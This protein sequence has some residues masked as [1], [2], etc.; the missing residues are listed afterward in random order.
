MTDIGERNAEVG[1]SRYAVSNDGNL[2]SGFSS[3]PFWGASNA[4][5]WTPEAGMVREFSGNPANLISADGKVAVGSCSSNTV[6]PLCRWTES[7]GWVLSVRSDFE[8]N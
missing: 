4:F 7:T 6:N 1:G 5:R 2:V 3:Q 8:C